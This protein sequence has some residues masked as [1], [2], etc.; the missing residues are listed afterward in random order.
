MNPITADDV[1]SHHSR[2][3]VISDWFTTLQNAGSVIY[4]TVASASPWTL[5]F[6]GLSLPFVALVIL[7]A[8][9]NL[10]RIVGAVY[11]T[12]FF[13]IKNVIAGWKT[14][15]VI[16]LRQW[17][18]H[19]RSHD[20]DAPPQVEFDDFDIAVLKAVASLKPGI[21]INA[22]ELAQ[23]FRTRPA[24]VQRCLD[25]LRSNKMLDPVIGSNKGFDSYRLTQLGDAFMSSWARRGSRA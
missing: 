12:I 4:S 3:H 13:R 19:R 23:R 17:L 18:P 2:L 6:V 10:M 11:G 15:F 14:R 24:R 16:K 20:D 21:V 5:L 9:R 8:Y 7:S 25:K 22:P 1:A